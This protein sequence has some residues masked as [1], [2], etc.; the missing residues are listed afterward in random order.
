[1]R[2]HS[3]LFST[4]MSL[5]VAACGDSGS[6]T[7]DNSGGAGSTSTTTGTGGAA[8]GTGGGATTGTGGATAGTGG[9]TAGTGGATA[10]TGG[11]GG[12]TGAGGGLGFLEVCTS[13]DQCASGLCHD[14]PSKG[15][16][17]T[18]TCMSNGD[19]PQP[20]TGCNGMGV[21]KAP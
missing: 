8:A 21:C 7:G 20:S 14:F 6:S 13:N 3:L 19:C 2:K 4:L 9:A 12:A 17:C 10:G 1:M 15:M 18:I 11:A 16:F 5:F